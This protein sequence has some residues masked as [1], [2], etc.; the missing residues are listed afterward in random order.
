MTFTGARG[1]QA[2]L[3]G[4]EAGAIA[5]VGGAAVV[6]GVGAFGEDGR[7]FKVNLSSARMP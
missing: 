1:F 2:V 5:M 3:G 4:V 7:H 6:G